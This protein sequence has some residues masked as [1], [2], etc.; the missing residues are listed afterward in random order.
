MTDICTLSRPDWN[1]IP[2]TGLQEALALA[3]SP[4]ALVLFAF[5]ILS[6]RFRNQ[7]AAL[8]TLVLWAGYVSLLTMIDPTKT[9]ALA[10]AE[11]CI[12]SPT[13]FI[14]AVAAICIGLIYFTTPKEARNT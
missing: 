3:T 10:Q 2:V 9:R 4:A 12:G 7:W 11:G 8:V 6:I 13:L 14:V 1:G 5:T